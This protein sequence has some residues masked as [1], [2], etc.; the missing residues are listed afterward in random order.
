MSIR[1]SL[2]SIAFETSGSPHLALTLRQ[3]YDGMI[4]ETAESIAKTYGGRSFEV[5]DLIQKVS[6]DGKIKIAESQEEKISLLVSNFPYIDAEVRFACREY[7]CTIEDILS[8][9]T[10]LAF[11]NKEAA[12]SAINVVANIMA[13]ELGWSETVKKEQMSAARD[14]ISRYAGKTPAIESQDGQ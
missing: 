10:R 11:L 8:R 7:A 3:K 14:Y 9:R 1:F 13:E 5:C 12:L 6:D 2:T 4:Y